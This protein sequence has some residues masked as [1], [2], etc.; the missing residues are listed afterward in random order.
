[1]SI[2]FLNN[3]RK[4]ESS[5]NVYNPSITKFLYPKE[6][7]LFDREYDILEL[8]LSVS[9]MIIFKNQIIEESRVWGDDFN[10]VE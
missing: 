7:C 9:D 3:L 5:Q 10:L 1:M 4:M 6:E 2:I 8:V